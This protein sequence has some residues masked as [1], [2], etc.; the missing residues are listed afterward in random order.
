MATHSSILAWRIPVDRGAWWA[1]IH[2]VAKSHIHLKQFSTQHACG[3]LQ[4]FFPTQ[5]LNPGLLHL[6]HWQ[7]GPLPLAPPG[8]LLWTGRSKTLGLCITPTDAEGHKVPPERGPGKAGLYMCRHT[9]PGSNL[10]G[11][12]WHPFLPSSEVC[13][14]FLLEFVMRMWSDCCC[15]EVSMGSCAGCWVEPS[16]GRGG[17]VIAQGLSIKKM[18]HSA[19]N[20]GQ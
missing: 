4:G 1:T 17:A 6:L 9:L 19:V 13:K 7:A 12:P 3:L 18:K 5:G 10:Q 2:G 16:G 20:N 15:L 14:H 8:K 11:S